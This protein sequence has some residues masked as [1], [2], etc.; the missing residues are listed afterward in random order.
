MI[1]RRILYAEFGPELFASARLASRALRFE[2]A[3]AGGIPIIQA[4]E[5]GLAGD[6]LLSIGGVLNG[7]SNYVLTRIESSGL[8]FDEA[9]NEARALGYAD[10]HATHLGAVARA[11]GTR[12]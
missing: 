2:A 10:A 9:L 6:E 1:R 4:I 5:S 11:K 8:P 12:A 7:T 3:V